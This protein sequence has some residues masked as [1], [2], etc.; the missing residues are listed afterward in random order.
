V[1]P[2]EF[3]S[4][5]ASTQDRAIEL[6]RT[7]AAEGTYVVAGRQTH[8]RG[9][10]D[11]RWESPTGG[12]YLSIILSSPVEHPTLLPLALGAR[13]AQELTREYSLPFRVKWPNDV[14]VVSERSGARKVAGV[15]VD[16][17]EAPHR[18]PVAVAGIGVNVTT[19]ADALP[20]ELR[21]QATSLSRW[22]PR[23]LTLEGVEELVV[24][25]AMGASIGLREL[26]GVEAT[27]ILCRRSL[28]GVGHRATVDGKN[29]GTIVGLGD[30]GE[31]L[32]EREGEEVA[33]SAGDV[34]VGEV[35]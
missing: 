33:I 14:L 7:G 21:D 24:R 1:G 26:G 19:P 8:G 13:L 4:E 16:R 15:L 3:H 17:V 28:W 10:L 27:R 20:P 34:R 2:R 12:V 32:L 30:E 31:L 25:A 22:V 18:E 23:A 6:A 11:H 9:R 5:I 29:A 35:A